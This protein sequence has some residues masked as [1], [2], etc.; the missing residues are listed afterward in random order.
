MN[1]IRHIKIHQQYAVDR[2]D[3]VIRVNLILNFHRVSFIFI[4]LQQLK[5]PMLNKYI[6]VF[7]NRN[8]LRN[9]VLAL[10]I[11]TKYFY[12]KYQK[13]KFCKKKIFIRI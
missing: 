12:K 8:I 2:R 5:C 13:F 4:R 6:A 9:T 1:E 10:E 3:L 7:L 11:R